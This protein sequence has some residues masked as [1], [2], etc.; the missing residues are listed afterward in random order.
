MHY[1]PK[2]NAHVENREVFMD[3][4]EFE[5]EAPILAIPTSAR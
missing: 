2:F 1:D 4:H 3:E 5:N